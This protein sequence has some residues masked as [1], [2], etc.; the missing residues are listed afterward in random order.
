M[1]NIF[2]LVYVVAV[3][4][5]AFK[6]GTEAVFLTSA[7]MLVLQYTLAVLN[8]TNE[9]APEGFLPEI[10]SHVDLKTGDYFIPMDKPEREDVFAIDSFL[11]AADHS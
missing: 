11:Y 2:S 8:L 3:L 10:N 5:S 7:V 9:S 6:H 1:S 4:F